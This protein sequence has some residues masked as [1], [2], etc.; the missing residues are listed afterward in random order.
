MNTFMAVDWEAGKHG[1]RGYPQVS[2]ARKSLTNV[3]RDGY[4][5]FIMP[6]IRSFIFCKGKIGNK[7]N[8]LIWKGD[9]QVIEGGKGECSC[10]RGD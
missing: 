6:P 9:E 7:Y 10:L 8:I 4:I 2:G 3:E 5:L 1:G